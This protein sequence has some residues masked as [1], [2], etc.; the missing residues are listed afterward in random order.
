[1][2]LGEI[3]QAGADRAAKQEAKAAAAAELVGAIATAGAERV[4]K[5]EAKA[6]AG[7]EL[8]DAIAF[9]GAERA[10]KQEAK[11]AAGAELVDAIAAA[12]AER[13]AKQQ[14]KADAGAE[15]VDAIAI[16]GAEREQKAAMKAAV[17]ST[18]VEMVPMFDEAKKYL[19]K[20]ETV[21]RSAPVL[22]LI[23]PAPQ[24]RQQNAARPTTR[25]D[26][27]MELAMA[28]PTQH[29]VAGAGRR[30]ELSPVARS[31]SLREGAVA[32]SGNYLGKARPSSASVAPT[33]KARLAFEQQFDASSTAAT[34]VAQAS[35]QAHHQPSFLAQSKAG[36]AS[37]ELSSKIA[38]TATPATERAEGAASALQAALNRPPPASPRSGARGAWA[39][40][41]GSSGRYGR[42]L[43]ATS[44]RGRTGSSVAS[45][46]PRFDSGVASTSARS[47]YSYTVT[48]T[49]A[50]TTMPA[51]A[52]GGDAEME[53]LR[54]M[55][56]RQSQQITTMASQLQQ[57]APEEAE[58]PED[59]VSRRTRAEIGAVLQ[60]IQQAG[61]HEA[62]QLAV[63][64]HAGSIAGAVDFLLEV[65]AKTAKDDDTALGYR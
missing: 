24:D 53:E 19:Q 47:S 45:S 12:G 13:A 21:D 55:M 32:S 1:M 31:L 63:H 36:F 18:I 44:P 54:Q 40:R 16:A 3:A 50:A 62:R 51:A 23:S 43:S 61:G 33:P 11:A 27:A 8:V 7:A 5:Q 2:P 46:T 10:A 41:Q 48:P 30:Q 35:S 57:L 17:Q 52:S 38:S 37:T 58:P 39:A 42:T 59:A 49:A 20:V 6:A 9:A 4:A 22:E 65:L 26:R 25:V 15:L 64:Q 56:L 60:D 34:S 29:A 14:A 28:S